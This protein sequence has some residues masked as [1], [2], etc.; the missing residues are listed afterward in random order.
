MATNLTQILNFKHNFH[1]KIERADN[2]KHFKIVGT[3]KK[4][5]AH[6]RPYNFEK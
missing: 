3:L 6:I 4:K 2:G 5:V 1:K